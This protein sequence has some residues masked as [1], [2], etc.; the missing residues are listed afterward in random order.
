MFSA[1]AGALAFAGPAF[2]VYASSQALGDI[3]HHYTFVSFQ[4][5]GLGLVCSDCR[6]QVQRGGVKLV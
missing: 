5:F 3:F 2:A 6:V 1:A 4:A